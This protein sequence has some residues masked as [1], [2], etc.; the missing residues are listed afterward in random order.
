MTRFAV[1]APRASDVEVQTGGRRL[2]LV[3]S[4]SGWHQADDPEAGP[5]DD[6]MFVLDGGVPL[7]DPRSAWQPRGVHDTSRLLDHTA[8]PWTDSGWGGREL[9]DCVVYEMHT[10]T[11]TPA[12]TLDGA[13]ERIPDLVALGVTA[14]DVMPVAAFPGRHGWGYDCVALYAVHESYGG[15]DALRRFVDACHR[16]GLAVIMDVVYN[17]LGPAGNVLGAFGPYFTSRHRNPWGDALNVDGAGSDEVRRFI[18]DNALMWL[19]DYH[20]DGLRLD[21][22]HAILDTSAVHLVEEIATRVHAL[23]DELGRRLWVIAESDLNDPRVVREPAEGGYGCD[24]QWSDD[25][26]HSLHSALT[27][28]RGGYYADFGELVDIAS[29][30]RQVFVSPGQYSRFRDRRH[31]RDVGRLLATR[32]LGYMQDHDQV[33]NRARGERTAALMSLG[34][35][36]IAAA[37]VLLGPFV[38]MLFQ[39]EEWAASSPFQYFTDHQDPLLATAVSEGRRAEFASFGWK[40]DDVPDPQDPSTFERSKLD[41]SEVTDEPHATVL[42]WHRDLIALRAVNSGLRDGDRSALFVEHDEAAR[43]LVMRRRGVTV[44]CNWGDSSF[45]CHLP[46]ADAITSA[47]A[48]VDDGMIHLHP[49]SVAVL[50]SGTAVPTP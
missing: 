3:A 22:V 44:V 18:V 30:L 27:G 35:L 21:A 20:L 47:G 46:A 24:A 33:G 43:T 7:P 4:D 31:G 5:G 1:W 15:P 11:F 36:Q 38:P 16:A 23:A 9:P 37:L 6:Y 28:E 40:P 26:H 29:A 2:A 8:F 50:V 48:W 34:R 42:R 14:V 41:W 12:G 49:D 45:E 17:H 10:G 13:I 19:R 25:F 32:F 39:G